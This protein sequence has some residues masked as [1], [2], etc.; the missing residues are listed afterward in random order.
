MQLKKLPGELIFLSK[1]NKYFYI[2]LKIRCC[3]GTGTIVSI[4]NALYA[5]IINRIGTPEQ[6]MKFLPD[7]ITKGIVG[8]FAL[9]EPG[10]K[11]D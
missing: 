8:C 7:F 11:L 6:K 4:H 5:G 9:S 2:Y 1:Q 3:G 10:N